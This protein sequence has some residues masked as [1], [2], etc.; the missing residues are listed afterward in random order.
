MKNKVS[1]YSQNNYPNKDIIYEF[2]TL[3]ELNCSQSIMKFVADIGQIK[4][5]KVHK[6]NNVYFNDPITDNKTF[7]NNRVIRI[8]ASYK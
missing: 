2:S 8:Y 5:V 3:T 1:I 7:R 4:N 6:G